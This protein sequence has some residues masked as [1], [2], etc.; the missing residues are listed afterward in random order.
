LK[1]EKGIV[2]ITIF[3]VKNIAAMDSNGKSD[4]FIELMLN[5]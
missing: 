5:G 1:L 4:P 3:R 2:E